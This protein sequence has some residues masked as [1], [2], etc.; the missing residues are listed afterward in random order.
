MTFGVLTWR[1]ALISGGY[2]LVLTAIC[3]PLAL[4]AMRRRLIK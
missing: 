3:F 2:L 4:I 1:D